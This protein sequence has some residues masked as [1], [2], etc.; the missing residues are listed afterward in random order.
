MKKI[1]AIFVAMLMTVMTYTVL[2]GTAYAAD[3]NSTAGVVSTSS[4][5][6]NVRSS[7]SSSAGIITSL[8][9]NSY[10]T[11]LSKSGAWW[12]VEYGDG[13]YGYVHGDY[14]KQVS[15]SKA[16]TVRT[17]SG[18]LNVR[19]GAG[20]NYSVAATLPKGK[21]VVVLSQ[22][23]GWSKILYRGTSIGYASS[24][25]LSQTGSASYPAV[26]LSIP[27]YKQT[28]ARWADVK[29]GTSGKTIR[30]IGC[31]TTAL[32]MM[33]S[34]RTG[35]TIYPDAMSKKLTYS[36]SGDL[37]WPSNYV[38]TTNASQYL[39]TIYQQLKAGKPVLIGAKS[40]VGRQHWVVVTGYQ[41]GANLNPAQFTVNDP[42]SNTVKTLQQ[43]LSSHPNFYKLVYY[44]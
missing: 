30:Q 36:S 6:L 1:T 32:A 38:Q 21:N 9:R 24:Q 23:N 44:K 19:Q 29:L 34:Y 43:F 41:G 10:I 25:Y 13:R 12:Y 40:N 18:N 11:L 20:T 3:M 5:N 33:E 39:Q 7:P 4:G 2:S 16:A 27:D 31:T 37:Y 26:K 28:D 22:A 42:G 35:T 15:G 8:A 14:I 17:T